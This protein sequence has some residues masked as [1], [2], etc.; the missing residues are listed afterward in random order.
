MGLRRALFNTTTALFIGAIL[1]TTSLSQQAIAVTDLSAEG[2]PTAIDGVLDSGWNSAAI[3]DLNVNVPEGGTVPGTLYVMNDADN[4]YVALTIQTG[5]ADTRN[6]FSISFD[7]DNDGTV[8]EQGHQS[9]IINPETTT[10]PN[11]SSTGY[12]DEFQTASALGSFDVADGGTNDGAGAFGNDGAH[13][14]FEYSIPIDTA[15]DTRDFNLTLGDTI[16]LR[17]SITLGD[18]ISLISTNISVGTFTITLAG[19]SINTPPVLS[20]KPADVMVEPDAVP[21]VPTV[22]ATD[23]EDDPD[24]E[25]SFTETRTGAPF[26]DGDYTL[27]REWSATDSGD[28]SDSHTQT[29]SVVDTIP[30]VITV[31]GVD[32]T[33]EVG[34]EFYSEAGASATDNNPEAPNPAVTITVTD[35][36][37]TVLPGGV[38][39]LIGVY[40]VTY[41][42]IDASGNPSTESITVTI[43]DTTSPTIDPESVPDD[44]TKEADDAFG[45]T[46]T[47][48]TP[49][50][51]DNDPA[52]VDTTTCDAT[53]DGT[54]FPI[55]P[56]YDTETTTVT[57]TAEDASGNT[58]TATF[59]VTVE[60]TT[61]PTTP[62]NPGNQILEAT[63]ADGTNFVYQ[64]ISTDTVSVKTVTCEV[65][66]DDENG[67]TVE[68]ISVL[69]GPSTTDPSTVINPFGVTND[70]GQTFEFSNFVSETHTV[71][72]TATDF[73]GNS[74]QSSFTVTVHDTTAPDEPTIPDNIIL[75]A[76]NAAGT[77]FVYE[78]SSTDTVGVASIQCSVE[79]DDEVNEPS[80]DVASISNSHTITGL[81]QTD[82]AVDNDPEDD[83]TGQVFEFDDLTEEVHTV[84]CDATDTAGNTSDQSSFT[85]TVEDTVAPTI[86][87][88]NEITI[89]IA[90]LILN[91]DGTF[92]V[93]FGSQGGITAESTFVVEA[94]KPQGVN[95]EYLVTAEDAVGVTTFECSSNTESEVPTIDANGSLSK[96]DTSR[97]SVQLTNDEGTEEFDGQTFDMTDLTSETHTITC[98]ATDTAG[99]NDDTETETD[100]HTTAS[101]QVTVEDT[102]PPELIQPPDPA[103][104]DAEALYTDVDIDTGVGNVPVSGAAVA[105]LVSQGGIITDS[106]ARTDGAGE[107]LVED[108]RNPE[109]AECP[110]SESRI[111][112]YEGG[113]TLVTYTATDDAGNS[114]SLDQTVT[115]NPTELTGG[116]FRTTSGFV[117]ILSPVT[118]PLEGQEQLILNDYRGNVDRTQRDTITIRTTSTLTSEFVDTTLIETQI[119]S[120]EFMMPTLLTFTST[121]TVDDVF[122]PDPQTFEEVEEDFLHVLDLD[123]AN[124]V[125]DSDEIIS[126][127]TGQPSPQRSEISALSDSITS[128]VNI[129]DPNRRVQPASSGAASGASATSD[130]PVVFD[131]DGYFFGE[132]AFITV[133]DDSRAGGGIQSLFAGLRVDN[134]VTGESVTF[135]LKE[136]PQDQGL[137]YATKLLT[138][139]NVLATDNTG[140][141]LHVEDSDTI[142][143]VFTAGAGE[144]GGAVISGPVPDGI[145]LD[146]AGV[147]TEEIISCSAD[148]DGDALCDE[149]ETED[150]LRITLDN[151][152]EYFLPCGPGT[153]DPV[154][155]NPLR[156]DIY[157]EIDYMTFHR[158][159]DEAISLVKT[160]FDQASTINPG[161]ALGQDS[162]VNTG[163]ELHVLIDDD[164]GA[165]VSPFEAHKD[166]MPYSEFLDR[167]EFFFG[168]QSERS[169]LIAA[170]ILTAKR[171]AFHYAMFIHSQ[172][173]SP[174]SSG[175]AEVGG[176]DLIV[177]LG[178]FFDGRGT[179][180]EQA[181]TLMHEIGH[182]L[183]LEH[184][185]GPGNV[186]NCKPNY[187]SVMNYAFQFDNFDTGRPL[188]YSRRAL[189]T[190]DTTALYETN[191]FFPYWYPQFTEGD[192]FWTDTNTK[193]STVWGIN[194]EP[195]VALTNKNMDW[196]NDSDFD[197]NPMSQDITNFGVIG[198]ETVTGLLTGYNDWAAIKFEFRGSDSFSSGAV[199]NRDAINEPGR[200]EL[201]S[202]LSQ[203]LNALRKEIRDL[204][205]TTCKETLLGKESEIRQIFTDLNKKRSDHIQEALAELENLRALIAQVGECEGQ[206]GGVETEI[207]NQQDGFTELTDSTQDMFIV[208]EIIDI[209]RHGM[210]NLILFGTP[211]F[212]VNQID[213]NSVLLGPKDNEQAPIADATGNPAELKQIFQDA[214][215]DGIIDAKFHFRH[216]E[217]GFS[218]NQTPSTQTACLVGETNRDV[219]TPEGTVTIVT[220]FNAC[221]DK[222]VVKSQN[223]NPT[224]SLT[225]SSTEN[226]FTFTVGVDDVEDPDSALQVVWKS[227]VDGV[228]DTTF[229]DGSITTTL[230]EGQTHIITATVTDTQ[231]GTASASLTVSVA[232]I[233]EPNSLIIQSLDTSLQGGKGQHLSILVSAVT[234]NDDT[235][236]PVEGA[237]V[238]VTV[239]NSSDEVVAAFNGLTDVNGE[240]TFVLNNFIK[241]PA[242]DYSVTVTNVS[243]PSLDWDDV[244]LST[245]VTNAG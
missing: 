85:V 1:V 11:C 245:I 205:D 237:E 97:E 199:Q 25:V 113:D 189:P 28:L 160:A 134:D 34:L 200:G 221:L 244:Q 148:T 93:T 92:E 159:S 225:T 123:V 100:G 181:E 14:V 216:D 74:A 94:T 198:C 170:D 176:N 51:T 2:T 76:T 217:T 62:T 55:A 67:S 211:E 195:H 171:Q 137:F 220:K 12:C 228:L 125:H 232:A 120:S 16:G 215:G 130:Q 165:E 19:A 177:S 59:N 89:E 168:T 152:N 169:S 202:L 122:V 69:Q 36:T 142:T 47:F 133:Q 102:T 239:T 3:N 31:N 30:P 96:G 157:L 87:L 20:P 234:P 136:Y 141:V 230:T 162:T 191:G 83:G 155:P 88:P 140:K 82:L 214:N 192:V 240:V 35:E 143:A 128:I 182:N 80:S 4:L 151:G 135:T 116:W 32:Q 60:D 227:S 213:V 126:L 121:P 243:H 103:A 13:S 91:P 196:D 203:Q 71:T 188:D 101:F 173:E 5:T 132:T 84:T 174:G 23:A 178:D 75:E 224:I 175:I 229:G 10:N 147:N 99:N 38:P 112:C 118:T 109:I 24:P 124:A 149:W 167:K 154:C 219:S 208:D 98:I 209:S 54:I 138:L 235:I 180:E 197:G 172:S 156:K 179:A 161:G 39:N 17:A 212:D 64:S 223:D 242:G 194:G 166:L 66:S 43:Q 27:T 108:N 50:A 37:D 163:I 119:D 44:I 193:L 72:C 15:D 40:T 117:E 49:T 8:P 105:D 114:V 53:S 187:I 145:P 41:S 79:S 231:G 78:A 7:D 184:G 18:G 21:G 29:I 42:S 144:T 206:T 127:F 110:T 77:D 164:M 86:T 241:L 111:R 158:P 186:L 139:S 26:G 207:N 73:A 204:P 81:G 56:S 233:V 46:T 65:T 146:A 107:I 48:S 129:D 22:T 153:D 6:S 201:S 57:C 63:N 183:N 236:L 33:L 218:A 131:K 222:T 52:F 68:T 115:V 226:P 61:N 58:A 70:P 9:V 106:L 238:E 95:I 190:L 210:I 185:G 90:E 150:G 104:V 45:A